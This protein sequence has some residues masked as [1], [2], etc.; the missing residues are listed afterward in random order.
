MRKPLLII[1]RDPHH[2]LFDGTRCL[3][4]LA[5]VE[6]HLVT[7]PWL[8]EGVDSGDFRHTTVCDFVDDDRVEQTCGWIVGANGIRGIVAL[9]EKM[10]IMAAR[11]RTT[12]RLPG[13]QLDT[14]LL[15]RDKVRMKRAVHAHGV[16]VPD[17]R[18]LDDDGDLAAV[19]WSRGRQ[20]IKPRR[21]VGSNQTYVV[22]SLAAAR[23]VWRRIGA[24]AGEYE[25]EEFVDGDMFHCDGIVRDGRVLHLSVGQYH[26]R[27][28]NVA[29]GAVAGSFLLP[30]G[31][32]AQRIAEMHGRVVDAL[33]LRS[34]V[35]HL[36]VFHTPE[37]RL[38]FC[39]IAARPGGGG[40]DRMVLRRH[41]VHLREAAI[42]IE[43]D[44]PPAPAHPQASGSDH[45]VWGRVGIYPHGRAPTEF[46]ARECG[47]LGVA[48]Y[49][50]RPSAGGSDHLPRHSTDY[51]HRFI[52]S[53]DSPADFMAR[54]DHLRAVAAR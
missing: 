24:P 31:P 53:G 48:E 4:P 9:H 15:F 29:P 26:A 35:T 5:D 47:E 39:E 12:H 45:A 50:Y 1:S 6:P 32:V 16:T 44:L 22:D 2:T 25:I 38:V 33:G 51:T 21:G 43:A 36:E 52:L 14:A 37:G 11:L 23:E 28:G 19:D 10:V 34:G 3:L 30:D 41:G 40:I 17:F 7:N 8:T 46:T 49:E 54:V 27:P 42:R 13:L 18:A 20:I